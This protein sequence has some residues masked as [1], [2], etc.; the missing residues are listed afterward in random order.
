MLALG[1]AGP[2]APATAE[3]QRGSLL[4]QARQQLSLW[5]ASRAFAILEL[6]AR[7]SAWIL[8]MVIVGSRCLSSSGLVR[9]IGT[10]SMVFESSN[11][12]DGPRNVDSRARRR[13]N[14]HQIT[15]TKYA[16]VI[17]CLLVCRGAAQTVTPSPTTSDRLQHC[18]LLVGPTTATA[19]VLKA[20]RR[21]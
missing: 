19:A 1:C 15:Y 13:N 2:S 21:A 20:K 17:M 18:A 3:Q 11:E 5:F 4:R 6:I 16:L 8:H 10:G 7:I 12:S 9:P 14:P